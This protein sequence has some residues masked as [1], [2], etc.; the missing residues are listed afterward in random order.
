MPWQPCLVCKEET[1]NFC[2]YCVRTRNDGILIDAR[3]YCDV[4]C[5][6]KDEVEHLKVHMNVHRTTPPN[7]ERATKAG[8]IA[9]SLFYAFLENTWTY[10]M[11]NVCIKRDQDHDL[12]A[13]EVTDGTGVVTASGGHTDCKSYAGGWL[14]KFPAESFSAFDNDAKHAL[15]SDRSSIWAFV[16]MH[17]A[18]QALFQDLVDDVQT[19][20]KE[21]VHYP[22]DKASRVVHAQGTFGFETRRHDQVYPDVDERG[23]TKGVYEI[24]LKCGAKIVLDLAA[25]QWDLPDGNGA[26]APV[27]YW[28]DYW[29]RWGAAIKYRIPFRSHALKH[30]AKMSGYRVVTSQTLIMETILYFNVL[31]SSGCKAEL[32][33][34]P[35]EL[36]DMNETYSDAKMRFFAQAARYLQKRPVEVDNGNHRNVLDAFDLRHPK[37]IADAPK[38]QPNSNGS[39]PLDIGDMARFDWKALSRLIQ[40]PSSEV[41]LKEKK[42]AKALQKD[43]SVYKEPGTWKIVFLEDTLPGPRVPAERVSENPGWKLG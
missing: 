30:A 11:K 36:L 23:D 19:D 8:K 15:L 17:A 22:V 26:Q 33:F 16:V 27:M 35:R 4:D 3:F 24:T 39:L 18:V 43:R 38:P 42:R 25:A 7:M 13:V 9:Q 34:H 21:V 31:M 41:S 14:I 37:V 10:D 29:S 2:R 28:A 5:R 12:V 1:A 32:G 40:Q 6:K 20:I